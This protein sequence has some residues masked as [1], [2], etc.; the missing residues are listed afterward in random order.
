MVE[1]V[2]PPGLVTAKVSVRQLLARETEKPVPV[3][4]AT[5]LAILKALAVVVEGPVITKREKSKRS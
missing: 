2:L 1:G 4:E 5:P 3:G